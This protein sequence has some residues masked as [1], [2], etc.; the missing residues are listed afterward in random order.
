[1]K[2]D[3]LGDLVTIRKGTKL[4]EVDEKKDAIR[5]IMIGDLRNDENIKYSIPNNKNIIVNKEDLIIAWDGANAGLVG[6]NLVGALGST[7]ARLRLTD[8]AVYPNY[9]GLYLQDK[10]QEI[11]DGCTGAT[12]PHVNR[13]QL[14]TMKIPVPPIKI[15]KQIVEVL[16]EAQSLID[17][18][19]NQISL[20]DSL[21]ESVFYDMFG[22]PTLND[23]RWEVKR[24]QEFSN[25]RSSKRVFISECVEEGIPFYRGTEISKLSM[26][27]EAIPKL[28]ITEEHYKTLKET[29]GVPK[30]GDLLLPSICAKGEVWRVDNIEP[31][32]FKDGRVLWVEVQSDLVNS[33]YLQHSF[34]RLL[35]KDFNG[36]ASGSTFAEMKI[37]ILKDIKIPIPPL[38]LQNKFSKEMELIESQ[39]HLLEDSLQLL[40]NNYSSLMQRAFKGELF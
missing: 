38:S 27:E 10:F 37:F 22:D 2:W 21:I 3:K 14:I 28:H 23:K 4:I 34:S 31:F 36:I 19:K 33:R 30:I 20:L 9:L 39:K 1:M 16:N 11:R 35:V 12:I 13:N 26:G 17:N 24:F 32:Y 25:V 18:R 29:S 8:K 7:L 6:F 40:E 5:M 15:Q